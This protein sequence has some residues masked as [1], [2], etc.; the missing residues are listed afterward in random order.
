MLRHLRLHFLLGTIDPG[1]FNGP[2]PCRRV[3]ALLQGAG[4]VSRRLHQR[5]LT[6]C[7]WHRGDIGRWRG[8]GGGR[9]QRRLLWP[10]QG[11]HVR[12]K[13][14]C[15]RRVTG[16]F[17]AP[18]C[19]HRSRA[20]SLRLWPGRERRPGAHGWLGL[21]RN[22]RCRA[23]RRRCRCSGRCQDKPT[24]TGLPVRWLQQR[25]LDRSTFRLRTCGRRRQEQYAQI[26][27][28]D[29]SLAPR[30]AE[31]R[32]PKSL[33]T[34][35]QAQQQRVN[36]KREQERESQ[37][38]AFNAHPMAP[39]VAAP[40][41]SR[42]SRQCQPRWR[43]PRGAGADRFRICLA[44]PAWTLRSVPGKSRRAVRRT[45]RQAH[46]SFSCKRTSEA[47]ANCIR[48][49]ALSRPVRPACCADGPNHGA[50]RRRRPPFAVDAVE[51]R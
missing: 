36:Q 50:M 12:R 26:G 25:L 39:R 31:A 6:R 37:P 20:P 42:R 11:D 35:G 8:W 51:Q 10:L 27:R 1:E 13:D 14:R 48:F 3:G 22:C 30:K 17:A 5:L 49:L 40:V 34:E 38:P 21:G 45:T 16:A 7:A 23:A 15:G 44:V 47:L 43:C 29:P 33:A 4:V 32:K 9:G 24:G 2:R 41:G 28:L 19:N 18:R 46:R